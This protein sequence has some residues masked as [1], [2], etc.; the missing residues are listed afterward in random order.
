MCTIF[1][2]REKALH[3]NCNIF[4]T[5]NHNNFSVYYWWLLL[6]RLIFIYLNVCVHPVC[7]YIVYAYHTIDSPNCISL[8]LRFFCFTPMCIYLCCQ[9][10]IILRLVGFND[11]FSIQIKSIMIVSHTNTPALSGSHSNFHLI[12]ESWHQRFWAFLLCHFGSMYR[13]FGGSFSLVLYTHTQTIRTARCANTCNDGVDDKKISL[14]IIK[15]W[16][17]SADLLLYQPRMRST[18]QQQ[19]GVN[20]KMNWTQTHSRFSLPSRGIDY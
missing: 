11:E 12:I 3:F 18:K 7:A 2:I 9:W 16:F 8:L 20:I 19:K 5:K 4:Q 14:F 17:S 13:V 10:H 15:S 6:L 1:V